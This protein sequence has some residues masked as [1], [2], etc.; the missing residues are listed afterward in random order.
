MSLPTG[1]VRVDCHL[2]TEFSGDAVTTV[3]QLASRVEDTGLDVVCI[4]DHHT[5]RGAH[6]ALER[7]LGIRVIV[8]EE[9]RTP[10]GELIG[11]FLTERVPYVLPIDE[12]V[13]RIRAQRALVYAPHPCDPER[14]SIGRRHAERLA[15]SGLLD[16]IETFNAKV[17]QQSYN[18]DAV[19]LAESLGLTSAAGSDA[20]DPE[21]VGAAYVEMP[22]FDGPQDFLT[23]LREGRLVGSLRPHALRFRPATSQQDGVTDGCSWLS[24]T[25]LLGNA[26][27]V[28]EMLAAGATWLMDL[29]AETAPPRHPVPVDHYPIEDLMTGQGDMIARAAHRVHALTTAGERVGIYCQA[30]RSRTAAVA[31]AYLML[32]GASVHDALTRVREVRPQA[33]PA[34]ELMQSLESWSEETTNELPSE[35]M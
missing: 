10:A 20:H 35:G 16:I 9:I 5:I 24:K 12:V 1:W 17:T 15:G 4:T 30:G 29:R 6:T 7:D 26:G 22:D 31:M 13:A 18:E 33:M 8:G 14:A 23:K 2:H 32:H 19:D 27:Q 34:I 11:L 3:E 25:V 21:G 28:G